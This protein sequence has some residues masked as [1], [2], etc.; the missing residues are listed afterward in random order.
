MGSVPT[1]ACLRGVK[2]GDSDRETVSNGA[3][4]TILTAWRA[5]R[6]IEI[7]RYVG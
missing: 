2:F 7:I 5:S 4:V 1:F 6:T 3:A